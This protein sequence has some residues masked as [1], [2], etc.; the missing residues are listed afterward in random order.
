MSIQ[1]AALTTTTASAVYTSSGNTVISTMHICNTGGSTVY[2]NVYV[3][4]SGS[5]A[6]STNII[7]ANV[8]VTAFNTLITQEKFALSNGDAVFANATAT[9]LSSTISYIGI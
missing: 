5:I 2:A 9:G 7:Y 6:N 3:V 1:N 8:A 4:P